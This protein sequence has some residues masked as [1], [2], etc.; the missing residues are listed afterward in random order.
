MT[1]NDALT[2]FR[3]KSGEIFDLAKV[4]S[5]AILKVTFLFCFYSTIMYQR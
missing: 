5:D 3:Q 2:D 4:E 1:R